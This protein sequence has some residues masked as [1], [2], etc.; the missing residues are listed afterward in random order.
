MTKILRKKRPVFYNIA[1]IGILITWQGKSHFQQYLDNINL[2]QG[3][4]RNTVKIFQRCG[5]V[6]KSG[7]RSCV[8]RNEYAKNYIKFSKNK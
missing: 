7:Y 3:G 1:I 6:W 4:S 2:T 8:M 5:K